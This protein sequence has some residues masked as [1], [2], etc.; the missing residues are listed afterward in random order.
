[1]LRMWP[2]VSVVLLLSGAA[3]FAAQPP[4]NPPV[5]EARPTTQSVNEAQPTM[6]PTAEAPAEPEVPDS[7]WNRQRLTGD[8]GTARTAL[9]E[10]GITL[11]LGLTSIFQQNLKGGLRTRN[12]CRL[13]GS[14]DL[15]LTLDFG[16]LK[17]WPGG[18]L[19]AYAEGSWDEGVSRYVGD[20]F[21][22]NADVIAPQAIQLSELW[23]EQALLADKL[24]VRLGKIDLLVDFDTN[25][26]ANDPTGQFLNVALNNTANVPFPDRGHGLQLV[27]AP[28]D[29]LYFAAAVADAEARAETTGF[30]TA[31]HGPT[32]LF[33]VYEFG[34][35]PVWETAWGALPGQYRFGLWYDPQP[36]EVFFND[37]RG[38]RTTVPLRRDDVGFYANF[39]QVVFRENPQTEGDT[40]G[41]GAFCR[42][43]FAHGDVN[44][45]EHFWSLGAQYQGLLP[46]R[47]DDVLG[48][49]VAQG[50]LSERLRQTGA[51][52]HRETVLELYYN[53]QVFPW[54]HVSPDFQWILRPGGENG[55]DAF[56]AGLRVQI[57]F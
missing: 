53:V 8:W 15:E 12:A 48:F 35:T 41:L 40:Q 21:G 42:Y 2:A 33:S 54:L 9:E 13:S 17:L 31:Y 10:R 34:L 5:D 55:R 38:R 43:G 19:Y 30:R 47:D 29:W 50:I 22:V 14:Y 32:N 51:D 20:L 27:A 46:T 44:E 39:D 25:A 36:K 16:K 57:A 1:M 37:V 49:G 4:E 18:T 28:W 45:V 6:P 52:P 11:D 26:F 56:V 7:F 3:A 24:R 23:Y